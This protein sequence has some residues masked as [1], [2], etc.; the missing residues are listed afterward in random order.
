MTKGRITLG[1][2]PEE[3]AAYDKWVN[4]VPLRCEHWY[5]TQGIGEHPWGRCSLSEGHDGDHDSLWARWPPGHAFDN[6]PAPEPEES[7]WE[8]DEETQR[9]I[10]I[11]EMQMREEHP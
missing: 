3:A 2:T 5:G 7:D 9:A 6:A 11:T 1:A 4:E 8:P 10:A